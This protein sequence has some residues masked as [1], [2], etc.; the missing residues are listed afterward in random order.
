MSLKPFSTKI[1]EDRFLTY[2]S[3]PENRYSIFSGIFGIG[4]TYFLEKFFERFSN[5]FEYVRLSPVDYSVSRNEDIFEYI[6]ND[7]AFELFNR[8][9]QE[10]LEFSKNEY[11][12]Y[13]LKENYVNVIFDLAKN[14]S[15]IEQNFETI[16][17]NIEIVKKHISKAEEPA[18][19][20]DRKLIEKFFKGFEEQIGT[21]YETNL[22]TQLINGL[23]L[24]WKLNAKDAFEDNDNQDS[25]EISRKEIVLV[26]DDLDRI[27]P[28]HIFRILNVFSVHNDY[29]GTNQHKFG[30]DKIMLVCD[31][32]N[33]RNIFHTKY[34]SDTDFSGYIDKF[35]ST[36]IFHYNIEKIIG[37]NLYDFFENISFSNKSEENWLSRDSYVT[38]FIKDILKDFL[39][40]NSLNLRRLVNFLKQ[41]LFIEDKIYRIGNSTVH[42]LQSPTLF[43]FA[44][45]E[46]LYGNK[47]LLLEAIIKTKNRFEKVDTIDLW[48][49]KMG[50]LILLIESDSEDYS[51]SGES[52][53][54]ENIDLDLKV[55]YNP[56][57]YGHSILGIAKIAQHSDHNTTLTD[58]EK[59]DRTYHISLKSWPLYQLLELGYRKKLSLRNG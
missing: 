54:Y 40:S 42:T 33:I 49:K 30:F 3:E 15:K 51:G 48:E 12:S 19:H 22:I 28:E 37:E 53:K 35:Y 41:K 44:F 34:G 7:I 52:L 16:F 32:Q 25:S 38:D 47:N 50:D 31:I 5:R 45:M 57:R 36:E 56:K 29:Q 24:D 1:E 59:S 26:I 23:V 6:K 8:Y 10:D 27:D 14:A 39:Y 20:T 58:L 9:P 43:I 55:D 2:L 18:E 11:W 4:K 13:Y 21:I 17:N 46:K